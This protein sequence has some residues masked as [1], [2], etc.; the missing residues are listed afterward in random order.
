MKKYL[1]LSLLP[2]LLAGC[3]IQ[4]FNQPPQWASAVTSHARFFGL[5]ASI[6]V[7]S[8][9]SVGVKIGWGSTT[10]SVVPCSTNR[11][12]AATVSDTFSIGQELNPFSTSI[13][14]D[15]QTGWEPDNTPVPRLQLFP[16]PQTP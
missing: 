16:S 1:S 12:Y 13:K 2:L 5:D 9:V 3:Q 8:G 11:V 14:E 4:K 6:P 7:S 10:W 15:V